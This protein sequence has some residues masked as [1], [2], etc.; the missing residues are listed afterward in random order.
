LSR[1][2]AERFADLDD[3]EA[4][5][6]EGRVLVAGMPV[7]NPQSMVDVQA[8]IS[9]A[10]P[11]SL[12]GSVKL[13]AALDAFA[14]PVAG[15]IAM[16]VGASAGGFTAVLLE[17]GARRVYAVDAGRGLLRD[18]LRRD[19]R[20]VDL[21][22]VNLGE[23]DS[24]RV[25]DPIELVTIDVSYLA[26]AQAVPQLAR[27]AIAPDADLIALVKPMFELRLASLPGPGRVAEAEAR[28]AASIAEAGW[29]VIGSIAS[30]VTGARGAMERFV[31]ARRA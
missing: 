24:V 25:C 21:G 13:R 12:R 19:P 18:E 7:R 28:A 8:A 22:G 29:S 30:P 6:R 27:I 2:V 11:R 17:R 26:L 15:R 10:V 23:L 14:I 20:C 9:L 16:D 1:L 5:I 31:H 3:P 4:A